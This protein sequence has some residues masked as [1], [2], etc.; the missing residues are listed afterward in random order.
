MERS[1]HRSITFFAISACF[2]TAYI[3][4]WVPVHRASAAEVVLKNGLRLQGDYVPL[5]GL[6][7]VPAP[8]GSDG[9]RPARPIMALDDGLRRT[10]LS[11]RLVREFL[12]KSSVSPPEKFEIWQRVKGAG[13]RIYNVGPIIRIEPFD[14]YGRRTFTMRG[15]DGPLDVIQGI[16]ELT[17]N[18]AKVEG[19]SHIWDMRI[20]P[21]SIP[22]ASLEAMFAKQPGSDTLDHVKKVARFY[23]QMQRYEDAAKV[24]ESA[25]LVHG[26]DQQ[27]K[28]D[29]SSSLRGI[30][31]LSARRILDELERRR[32]AGQHALVLGMLKE[33]PTD[34]VA[35]EI[36]QEVN[37]NI[38]KYKEQIGQRNQ[39]ISALKELVG[40]VKD[41]VLK[42]QLGPIVGEIDAE[43]NINTLGRMTAF[44]LAKDDKEMLPTEKLAIAISGWLLGSNAA[45]PN[46]PT[47]ISAYE[48]RDIVREY[49]NDTQ[50]LS[51]HERIRGMQSQEASSPKLID[52]LLKHMKPPGELP[53][54]IDDKPGFFELEVTGVTKEHLVRYL[55][56]LPPEY[57]PYRHYPTIVTLHGPA[58]TPEM[59]LDWWAGPWPKNEKRQRRGQAT[60]RGYIVVAPQWNRSHEKRYGYSDYEHAAVLNSLRD[61]CRHFSI[62]TDRVFLS[63]HSTGGDAA[64]DIG[65][66]HP[67]LWA[68]VVPITAWSRCYC[69]QYW[70]NA[71]NLPLYF[72]GGEKDARW[73]IENARDLDRYL[74]R[75]FDAT[76]VEYQ[77]RGR[78]HF[79]EEIQRIFDW[80]AP[81]RR[82][83]FPKKFKVVSMR[84]WD[85]FFW[86]VEMYGM[87]PKA[88]VAPE[89]WPPPRNTIPAPTEAMITATNGVSVRTGAKQVTVWLSP[90]ILDMDRRVK[91]SVNGKRANSKQPFIRP[92]IEVLLEDAR[93]RADRQ[94]PF[95]AKVECSTGR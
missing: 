77:G 66:A 71:R 12:D 24:L 65:L 39:V 94:H 54:P 81:H 95:W 92:E 72:V 57:D 14:E 73:I 10:F 82:D 18:W 61:A 50:T 9:A 91:I 45:T 87:P 29:I 4:D 52:L 63:G 90:E 83:F 11:K 86:W 15:R 22:T 49:L 26:K 30:K 79:Q 51:R 67:D 58:G 17:P 64:W 7:E 3:S 85:N 53:P 27:V 36:L 62:D 1:T 5:A 38:G 33:F 46:L 74:I 23:L 88:M 55:V 76:V 70:E 6:A 20:A 78:E 56:Q 41:E 84:P 34:G 68:G 2:I 42:K 16:T 35:G 37:E 43:M 89:K 31:Q 13:Q 19:I 47:A 25:L 59:Q 80:M 48:T 69:P 93:T 40:Q 60:R 28:D 8:T 44:R 21:S 75:G 32:A